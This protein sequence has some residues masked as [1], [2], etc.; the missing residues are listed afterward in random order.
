MNSLPAKFTAYWEILKMHRRAFDPAKAR[1]ASVL[2]TVIILPLIALAPAY[3]AY[4]IVDNASNTEIDIHAA[5][6]NSVGEPNE[7]IETVRV[8]D[9]A[10]N[11]ELPGIINMPADFPIDDA[12]ILKITVE[13]ETGA[14]THVLEPTSDPDCMFTLRLEDSVTYTDDTQSSGYIRLHGDFENESD[15]FC[16]IYMIDPFVIDPSSE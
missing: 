4:Q 11:G 1:L 5:T 15:R 16:S 3:I 9:T 6:A 8:F 2:A 7:I 14:K 10:T 12:D 13:D